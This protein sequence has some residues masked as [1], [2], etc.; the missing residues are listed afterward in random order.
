MLRRVAHLRVSRLTARVWPLVLIAIS[1][2]GAMVGA[3]ASARRDADRSRHA[4]ALVERLRYRS[5]QIGEL[6]LQAIVAT[7][8]EHHSL[9]VVA[10]EL[11]ARGYAIFADLTRMLREL[12]ADQPG[13]RSG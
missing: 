11:T 13:E 10:P 9:L 8:V 7:R 6:Q 5:E 4:Q 3:A 2:M 12:R 1:A